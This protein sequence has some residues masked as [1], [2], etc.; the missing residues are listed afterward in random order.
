MQYLFPGIRKTMKGCIPERKGNKYGEPYDY[1][2]Y[3]LESFLAAGVKWS[4]VVLLDQEQGWEFG[5]TKIARICRA[6]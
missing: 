3:C 1:K 2:V 5:V 4:S 6:E